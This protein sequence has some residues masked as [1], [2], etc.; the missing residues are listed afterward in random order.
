M[1]VEQMA[2]LPNWKWDTM[3]DALDLL[4][5]TWYLVSNEQRTTPTKRKYWNTYEPASQTEVCSI[6]SLLFVVSLLLLGGRLALS[7]LLDDH[8]IS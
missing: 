1:V 4:S 7:L 6:L 3:Q 2:K 5:T 8:T